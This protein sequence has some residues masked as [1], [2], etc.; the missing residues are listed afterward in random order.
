MDYVDVDLL[1]IS[2]LFEL[3]RRYISIISMGVIASDFVL[4][5]RDLSPDTGTILIN[6]YI[7]YIMHVFIVSNLMSWRI[8][9][10]LDHD[11]TIASSSPDENSGPP[12]VVNILNNHRF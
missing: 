10:I 3:L 5:D 8:W 6:L 9:G 4:R 2:P 1:S 12:S 11:R 7:M